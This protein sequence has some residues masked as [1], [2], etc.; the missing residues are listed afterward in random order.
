MCDSDPVASA[1]LGRDLHAC[2][3]VDPLADAVIMRDDVRA[4]LTH[5]KLADHGRVRAPQN[6]DD[7]AVGAAIVFDS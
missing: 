5:L 1:T 4:A 2:G 6:L 3:N 7:L